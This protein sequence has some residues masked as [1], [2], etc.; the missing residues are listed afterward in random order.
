MTCLPVTVMS[1]RLV[2]DVDG[3]GLVVDGEGL[4]VAVVAAPVVAV[5]PVVGATTGLSV[6]E[7][8]ARTKAALRATARVSGAGS[9]VIFVTVRS[10]GRVV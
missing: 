5:K 3:E 10:L 7:Q 8:D 9:R 4:V 1:I 2:A 6:C